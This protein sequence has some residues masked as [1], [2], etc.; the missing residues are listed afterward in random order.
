MLHFLLA[1]VIGG[2]S[3]VLAGKIMKI[4]NPLWLDVILG[5]VGGVVAKALF[6]LVGIGTTG[7]FAFVGDIIFGVIGACLLIFIIR[8]IRK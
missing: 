5:V 1:L 8:A 2:V 7:I 3:G 4:N 6:G